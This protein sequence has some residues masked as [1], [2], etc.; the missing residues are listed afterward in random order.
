MMENTEYDFVPF[1]VFSTSIRSAPHAK[2]LNHGIDSLTI[3][4]EIASQNQIDSSILEK[5]INHILYGLEHL[6]RAINS[7]QELLHHNVNQYIM[8]SATK[9]VSFDEY[10]IPTILILLP[11]VLR[12]VMIIHALRSQGS[13]PKQ[14]TNAE[15]ESK[16]LRLQL[17]ICLL[18][19]YILVPIALVHVSLG[20]ISAILLVPLLSFA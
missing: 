13:S 20:L 7:L 10:I 12:I 18:A 6:F 1:L 14:L 8:V 19:L 15:E 16:G 9:F 2:A 17:W 11:L 4:I 5:R 3:R